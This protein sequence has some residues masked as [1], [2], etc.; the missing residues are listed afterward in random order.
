M[1]RKEMM[2]KFI[3]IFLFLLILNGIFTFYVTKKGVEKDAEKYG[4]LLK[5]GKTIY[6]PKEELNYYKAVR[7][8][9]WFFYITFGLYAAWVIKTWF[10]ER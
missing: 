8:S 5:E 7:L 10:S 6:V 3:K 9:T 4:D 1:N 2:L